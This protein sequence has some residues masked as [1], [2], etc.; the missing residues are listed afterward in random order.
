MR[1]WQWAV[2]ALL[3]L[4]AGCLA[5]AE[6]VDNSP[7]LTV[8]NQTELA[9]SLFVNGDLIA[10]FS[11]QTGERVG[12]DLPPLPWDV[13]ARS[14]RGRVLASMRV[15]VGDVRTE[16]DADGVITHTTAFGRVDLSCGRLT[17][18]AG[19]AAPSGPAPGP[20]PGIPGD[21]AP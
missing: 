13:E 14:P 20:D 1:L 12:A 19:D 18:W 5:P 6:G 2:P 7:T 15:D 10:E 16:T 4:L 8:A 11:A 17:I 3:V 21:C 9:V